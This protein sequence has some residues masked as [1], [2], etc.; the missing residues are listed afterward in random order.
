MEKP[1][2]WADPIRRFILL[3][4]ALAAVHAQP[5]TNLPPMIRAALVSD[6]TALVPGRPITVG[7]HLVHREGWHTYWENPGDVGIPPVPRWR[8][9]EGW[10]IGPVRYQA[11]R[12][13]KMFDIT[14]HGFSGGEALHLVE[15]TPPADLAPTNGFPLVA[16]VTWMVCGRT[17][18]PGTY[19]LRLE[20]PVAAEAGVDPDWAK[21]FAAVRADHPRTSEAWTTAARRGDDTITLDLQPRVDKGARGT[22]ADPPVYYGLDKQVFSNQP[23]RAERAGAGWRLVLPRSDYGPD[24]KPDLD[25]VLHAA[26]GWLADGSLRYLRIKTPLESE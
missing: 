23:H 26:E 10:R 14:A 3:I 21:R 7:L 12:K 17:C 20:L 8:L 24:D 1:G 19:R 16:D 13:V 18:H 11:P 9:G 6:A 25:A 4:P 5:S 15:L 2:P 22:L